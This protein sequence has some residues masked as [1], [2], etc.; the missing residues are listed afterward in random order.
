MLSPSASDELVSSLDAPASTSGPSSVVKTLMQEYRGALQKERWSFLLLIGLYLLVVLLG[1]LAIIGHEYVLPR[2]RPRSGSS[3]EISDDEKP[4]TSAFD[5][6]SR[7]ETSFTSRVRTW[8]ARLAR[9]PPS[10]RVRNNLPPYAQH[11]SQYPSMVVLP[12]LNH[13]QYHRGEG[14]AGIYPYGFNATEGAS[15]N[16]PNQATRHPSNPFISP[17]DNQ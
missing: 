12:M 2:W 3:K 9:R 5:S 17:F 16:G 1:V 10:L 15:L 11:G 7:Q 14:T 6:A 4:A 13:E 8:I